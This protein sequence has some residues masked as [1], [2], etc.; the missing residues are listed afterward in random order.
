MQASRALRQV[1]HPG[2]V[3]DLVQRALGKSGMG[4]DVLS[5]VFEVVLDI[6]TLGL[7]DLVGFN[8]LSW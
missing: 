2:L 3:S 4:L 1:G 6:L 7:F 8:R 5:D